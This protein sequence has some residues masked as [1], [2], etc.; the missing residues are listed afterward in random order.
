[1]LRRRDNDDYPF[2]VRDRL[3]AVEFGVGRTV[4]E[5][6]ITLVLILLSTVVSVG[7]LSFGSPSAMAASHAN[8]IVPQA[9]R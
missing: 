5:L 7:G 8:R 3:E 9:H 6:L 4:A 2:Y 1:M